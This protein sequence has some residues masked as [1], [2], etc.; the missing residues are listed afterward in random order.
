MDVPSKLLPAV[1]AS[2]SDARDPV[3]R[4]REIQGDVLV[5]L[6]KD[7]ENFLFFRIADVPAFKSALRRDL[8]SRVTT[9]EMVQLREVQIQAAKQVGHHERLHLSGLNIGFT[10][11]GL[12]VLLGKGQAD[13]MDPSFISGA[14]AAARDLGDPVDADG[15]PRWIA[16]FAHDEIHGVLLLTGPFGGEG[17]ELD[18]I[19]KETRAILDLLNGSV[20]VVY[21]EIGRVRP[22]RGHEHF[23]FLDGVSQPGIRGLTARQNPAN[24]DQG[25]PGQDLLWPGEFV[26]GYPG[27]SPDQAVEAPGP[28]PEM[29]H[30]WMCD[31]AFMVF[32]R[33]N[34][35]VPEFHAFLETQGEALGLDP[36]LLGARMVGRWQS[37]APVMIAPLQ[38]DPLVG[39]DPLRNNDFEFGG[40]AKQRRC[41][42]A[43]HI[44]KTYPRDDLEGV[45]PNGEAGVQTHRIKRAG[46]PFGPEV[47]ED[48]AEDRATKRERGLMF[49]CYQTSITEQFEFVQKSWS[50]NTGFVFGKTRPNSTDPVTPGHDPIIGQTTDGSART[51]DE[52]LPNYPTGNTRSTLNLPEPFIVPTAAGYFFMPSILAL[53]TVLS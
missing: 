35:R 16:G 36:A 15:R 39:E 40:D 6:E 11:R 37:G 33:L 51:M 43:A 31:G 44:R 9:M 13:G 26:F 29:P 8:I 14:A 20:Q 53:Q 7:V 3:L 49:V 46:I 18:V 38:D 24:P 47:Q 52:P 1:D 45:V 4:T 25:L 28:E 30:P 32:R 19:E 42:Y 27:Q 10:H 17:H 5:G 12:E 41:P 34:Q 2:L 23:G 22:Q 50:N 48:E 21:Q